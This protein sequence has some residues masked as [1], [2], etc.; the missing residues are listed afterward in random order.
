MAR[1]GAV[2]RARA[3][4]AFWPKMASTN[5]RLRLVALSLFVVATGIVASLVRKLN[6]PGQAFMGDRPEAHARDRVIRV[7]AP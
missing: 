3:H 4:A 5:T 2:D 7:V 1:A 6:G